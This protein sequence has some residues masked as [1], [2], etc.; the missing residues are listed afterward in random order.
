[1]Y[2]YIYTWF[3]ICYF[4]FVFYLYCVCI[5]FI[6]YT[7]QLLHNRKP[8][9]SQC[10]SKHSKALRS[11]LHRIYSSILSICHINDYYIGVVRLL[12]VIHQ[13][14]VA[15]LSLI[16]VCGKFYLHVVI[17]VNSLLFG[18]LVRITFT[19]VKFDDNQQKI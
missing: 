15:I 14:R 8:I 17:F 12:F 10:N 2:I 4:I 3:H 19:Q 13:V 16:S 5:L 18:F 11:L 9:P 7:T 1:M 6:K